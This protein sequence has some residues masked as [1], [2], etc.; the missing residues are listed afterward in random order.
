[1]K[2]HT[3]ETQTTVTPEK[4]LQFLKEGKATYV[5]LLLLKHYSQQ[6]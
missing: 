3:L 6:L 1:M 2:A 4:A 5:F